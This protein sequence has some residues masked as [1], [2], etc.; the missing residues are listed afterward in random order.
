[1][2]AIKLPI[3]AG[4]VPSVD[5]HLLADPN[6]A[7]SDNTWLYSGALDGMP[8][9]KLLH[10]L[11]NP[12]ATVA[13]RVPLPGNDPSYLYTGDWVEFEN[14]STDFIHAPVAADS[15]DR[16]YWTSTSSAPMYNTAARIR[17]GQP[18][19]ILGI[20]QAGTLNVTA[21]GGVSAT[22]VSRAYVATLVSEYGEEGPSSD[23]FLIT[24]KLDDTFDV[25]LP[26]VDPSYLGVTRNIKKIRLYRTIVSGNGTTTYYLVTEVNALVTTQHYFD[27]MTDA[28]LSSQPLLE[29]TAW[30]E[31]PDLDGFIVMPNGIV[32]GYIDNELWFSEPYRPHA[33]PAAYSLTLEFQ[34]VGLGVIN[35]TLV[36]CTEGNPV[37]ASGVNPANITT[38]KLALFEP[39]LSKGS[40]VSTEEGVYYTSPNGL[41]LVNAGVAQ[42]ITKQYISK[43]QWTSIVNEGKV[44]AGRLGSAYYAFATGVQKFVQENAFQL[45]AFQTEQ[46]V[47][48]AEGFMI[49]PTNNNVGFT[50]A[51]DSTD[52]KSVRNDNLSGEVLV[53]KDGAVQWL[54]L[55]PGYEIEPYKWQ[56]K[57]FQTPALQNF[58]A[59]KTYIYDNPNFVFPNPQNFDINQEFDPDTQ[60][61]VV[62]IY[63]DGKLVSAQ[64]LRKS[65]ELHRLPTGFK[66]AFWQ[67]EFEAKVKIKSF[68]MA[69]S[70]K[71]LASV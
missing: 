67:I 20:P 4:M 69:T 13:F 7:Y 59:Y 37:T 45:D 36:V 65:G 1:M 42:N 56:S 14:S 17:L 71:E 27:T 46:A 62:R 47:G 64:E 53:V 50:Y 43:D 22:L 48:S 66:A 15:F 49:D 57:V 3:F 60:L 8:V 44:N 55:R 16:Y 39:C 11:A 24:G 10:T 40:I 9:K 23:P 35:Q 54:D 30:T 29:S 19:W 68:Q 28:A 32:A 34:I 52:I 26:A 31:P 12:N 18:G 58:A 5:K 61:A 25:T 51:K 33:W 63:A 38:S 2:A 21:S 6:A 41:V 70:V